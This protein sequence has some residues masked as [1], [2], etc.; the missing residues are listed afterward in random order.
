MREILCSTGA[1]IGRP[2]GRNYRLLE[3]LAKQLQCDGFELMMY[4]TWY[5]EVEELTAYVQ[6]LN[7]SIPVVHCEK[8]IGE[9]I[10]KGGQENFSEAFRLFEIN[11]KLAKD[12]GAG[13][14]LLQ[15]QTSPTIWKHIRNWQRW[16]VDMVWTCWW[17][18][19]YVIRKHL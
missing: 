7:L 14:E 19:W 5:E 12:I 13:M 10:S 16:R 17:K 4:D 1:I 9:S 3:D 11:C 8:K 2:N 15:M 6:G 18:M